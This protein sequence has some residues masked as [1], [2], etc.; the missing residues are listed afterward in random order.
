VG[1]LSEAG[2]PAD[3]PEAVSFA[4]FVSKQQAT[5]A[6]IIQGANISVE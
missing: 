6:A 1:R 2:F 5:Y 3:P 4:D